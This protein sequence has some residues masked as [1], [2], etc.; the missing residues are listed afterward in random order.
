MKAGDIV[1]I[2]GRG[3]F[4]VISAGVTVAGATYVH[5]ASISQGAHQKNG[6]R[7]I[8]LCGWLRDHALTERP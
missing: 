8:Q 3:E 6:F 1:T 4:R 5:V 7:P 2:D